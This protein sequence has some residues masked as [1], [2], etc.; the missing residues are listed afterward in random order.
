MA[1]LKKDCTPE[2]WAVVRAR[3][4]QY[5]AKHR[6]TEK[7]KAYMK[8][9]MDEYTRTEAYRAKD[10]ARYDSARRE[11]QLANFRK[12]AYGVTPEQVAGL[13]RAQAGRCAVCAREFDDHAGRQVLHCVDHCHVTGAFRGLLCRMCNTFE[14]YLRK[15]GL[16][17][18]GFAQRLQQY[19]DNPPAQQ[20]EELW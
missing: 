2:E 20:E 19:L 6:G 12:R 16:T 17:P 3:A 15:R 1:K 14:G 8:A 13:M 9:Y 11:S 5:D 10:N 18:A 7:R 4:R